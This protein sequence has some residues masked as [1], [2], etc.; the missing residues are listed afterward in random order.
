MLQLLAPEPQSLLGETTE[1]GNI[2]YSRIIGV[3]RLRG[4]QPPLWSPLLGETT[5][6]GNLAQ[7]DLT[8]ALLVPLSR[9]HSLSPTH[10][11]SAQSRMVCNSPW[12]L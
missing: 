10:H 7:Q 1:E 8:Q 11:H 6:E 2:A 5:A 3:G 4:E 9:R 12:S